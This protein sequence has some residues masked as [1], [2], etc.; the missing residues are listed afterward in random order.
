MINK[1]FIVFIFLGLIGFKLLMVQSG[2]LDSSGTVSI[3]NNFQPITCDIQA[4]DSTPEND[5]NDD[6][7]RDIDKCFDI[8]C[9]GGIDDVADCIRS[10]MRAFKEFFLLLAALIK[11]VGLLVALLFVLAFEPIPGMPIFWG[12]VLL[13]PFTIAFLI[14][15]ISLFKPAGGE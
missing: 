2:E 12:I 7:Y 4:G 1:M 15:I 5:T 13:Y 6:G 14:V 10:L 11:D 8:D 9:G 3:L